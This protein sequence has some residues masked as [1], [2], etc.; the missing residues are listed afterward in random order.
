MR[1][2]TILLLVFFVAAGAIYLYHH[3]EDL[4]GYI[5]DQMDSGEFL[6]IEPRFSASQIISAHTNDL[7]TS[8][9]QSLQEPGLKFYPYLLVEISYK[10]ADHKPLDG[11]LLWSLSDGELI[12]DT[13]TWTTTHGFEEMIAH[14]ADAGDYKI[15]KAL[16]ANQGAMTRDQLQS[17]LSL[18]SRTVDD[19][20]QKTRQKHLITQRGNQY[21]LAQKNLEI[22]VKPQTKINQ[23]LNTKPYSHAHREPARFSSTEIEKAIHSA[24]GGNITIRYAREVYLP[25]YNISIIHSDGTVRT[26]AWNALNGQPLTP[27]VKRA[28]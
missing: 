4:K 6:T 8:A 21:A 3:G 28:S 7:I 9:E 13:E 1:I 14:D 11:I 10:N 5:G 24:F 19:W 15:V 2:I 16:A 26:T 17:Y 22:D 25:I 18:S 23:W 20:I 12:T 27:K